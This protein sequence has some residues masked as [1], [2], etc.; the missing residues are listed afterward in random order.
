MQVFL[1]NDRKI[2]Q[3]SSPTRHTLDMPLSILFAQFL[4][5]KAMVWGSCV[6][7]EVLVY[8]LGKFPFQGDN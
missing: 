7:L 8:V 1:R 5:E 2:I 3:M 6:S 4:V